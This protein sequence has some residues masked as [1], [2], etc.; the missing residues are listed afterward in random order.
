MKKI[1]KNL[2]KVVLVV[3]FLAG[4]SLLLYPTVANWWNSFHAT[5]AIASYDETLAA[6]AP[7][8]YDELFDA[9]KAYNEALLDDGGRYFPSEAE[10]QH[11]MDLLSVKDS[12][13]LG[14]I[15]IPT[16]KINLPI[17]HGTSE[18]VLQVGAGHLEGTSLP[19]GG[20]STHTVISGH[21]GLPSAELFNNIVNLAEGDVFVIKVL[22]QT[23]TYQVERIRTVLPT[24]VNDIDIEPG[25]D[26]AT[27]VTCTP[28]GVNTHRILITGHRIENLPDDFLNTKDNAGLVSQTLIAA[29]IAA[30]ILVV[31]FVLLMIRSSKQKREKKK[32]QKL[33]AADSRKLEEIHEP[34]SAKAP[35]Q[36]PQSSPS[37]DSGLDQA[38]PSDN[39]TDSTTQS[40]NKKKPNKG[41]VPNLRSF[42]LSG[43]QK[44]A[45]KTDQA[46]PTHKTES[47]ASNSVKNEK[48]TLASV[49]ENQASSKQS[50]KS[51]TDLLASMNAEQ[52]ASER[53]KKSQSEKKQDQSIESLYKQMKDLKP[54]D[55]METEAKA[56][57]E[58]F[59]QEKR[60]GKNK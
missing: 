15:Q 9:A 25:R 1:K 60:S 48:Q 50:K 28:Y 13:I 22:N 33:A 34:E 43:K 35:N 40:M 6:L 58:Q 7:E 17:Y 24:E 53:T 4:L 19:I 29:I 49:K 10:H 41:S 57:Y 2:S 45:G 5:R 12:Q 44:K 11:Y 20:E 18:E 38:G 55:P 52:A 54:E 21:R 16:Q 47:S 32:K 27:L 3:T 56:L 39:H 14:T 37:K 46:D 23:I 36:T 59:E 30:V 31:L 42:L 51:E 8:Q 26:L